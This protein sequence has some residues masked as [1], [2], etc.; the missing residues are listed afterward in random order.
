M[1]FASIEQLVYMAAAVLFILGLKK[2]T[3]VKTARAGNRLA[4]LGML[5][6]V[7]MTVYLVVF[8]GELAIA[9][10]YMLGGL[11]VGTAI[12]VFLAKKVEMT[13]MPELVALLN[14]FGGASS[15]LVGLAALYFEI[16]SSIHHRLPSKH[17]SFPVDRA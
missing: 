14:G 8:D 4:S 2:L 16:C 6:A 5:V 11:V 13:E 1:D 17:S 9:L 10:P 7:A 15:A 3:K 12:G